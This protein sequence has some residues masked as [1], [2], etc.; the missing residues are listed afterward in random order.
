MKQ[1]WQIP[2]SSITSDENWILVNCSESK[3]KVK[4]DAREQQM[5]ELM[6]MQA[7]T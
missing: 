2:A 6:Q 5:S 3:M 4:L 1:F 7:L